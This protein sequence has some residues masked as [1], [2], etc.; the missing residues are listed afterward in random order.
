MLPERPGGTAWFT[1]E[2]RQA[3]SEAG[4]Q[5]TGAQELQYPFAFTGPGNSEQPPHPSAYS[6]LVYSWQFEQVFFSCGDF[7]TYWRDST[8]CLR[9][10][11]SLLDRLERSE[12]GPEAAELPEDSVPG[13][14]EPF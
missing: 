12:H 1:R 10:S 14:P 7:S 2:V 4:R 8:N 6:D 3:P 13:V 5:T 9:F 11:F